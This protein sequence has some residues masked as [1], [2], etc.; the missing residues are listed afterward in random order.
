[1]A[2]D[3]HVLD[4]FKVKFTFSW[5]VGVPK[6]TVRVVSVVPSL[7]RRKLKLTDKVIRKLQ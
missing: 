4:T 5:A 1:M 3:L 6:W 7:H 2:T